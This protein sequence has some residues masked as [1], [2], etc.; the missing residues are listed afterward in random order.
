MEKYANTWTSLE[1]SRTLVDAGIDT[2]TAD[3]SYRWCFCRE[4]D[5]HAYEDWLREPWPPFNE[6]PDE[7]VPC[8]SVGGLLR[9][10]PPEIRVHGK[11]YYFYMTTWKCEYS[12]EDTEHLYVSPYGGLTIRDEKYAQFNGTPLDCLTEMVCRLL[13]DGIIGTTDV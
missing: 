12:R 10:I 13:R 3:M 11:I 5:G 8:W 6:C 7:Q 2:H 4:Q 9:V 1:Q